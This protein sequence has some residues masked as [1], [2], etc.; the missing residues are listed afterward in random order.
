MCTIFLFV[1]VCAR[2]CVRMYEYVCVCVCVGMQKLRSH[3]ACPY[4]VKLDYIQYYCGIYNTCIRTHSSVWRNVSLNNDVI[5]INACATNGCHRRDS[6]SYLTNE[7][8][9][10]TFGS[11]RMHMCT[12]YMFTCVCMFQSASHC[13][14]LSHSITV[15]ANLSPNKVSLSILHEM[16]FS[17]KRESKCV[18][19][20]SIA[21]I[22]MQSQTRQY[23][24]D[25]QRRRRLRPTTMFVVDATRRDTSKQQ[26]TTSGERS[27]KTWGSREKKLCC[28]Y[29]TQTMCV[30]AW[31]GCAH[32]CVY[33]CISL[34]MCTGMC[35][36]AELQWNV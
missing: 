12:L 36:L 19:F 2:L 28:V 4:I 27:F 11:W 30:H 7:P 32:V 35:S 23:H 15:R 24:M 6:S 16:P 21:R 31:M 13:L 5:D 1:C 3:S 34:C 22:L 10:L 33:V 8:K 29:H 9:R 26:Q 14:S 20:F 25:Q 18:R 17:Y